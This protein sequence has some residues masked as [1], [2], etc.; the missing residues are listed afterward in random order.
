MPNTV[1]T[2]TAGIVNETI[3]PG[4]TNGGNGTNLNVPTELTTN[5]LLNRIG[6]MIDTRI[7][8]IRNE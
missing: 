8:A 2:T 5:E 7:Q 3:P 1:N 4:Q 6:E